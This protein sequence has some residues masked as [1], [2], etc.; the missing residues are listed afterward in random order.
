MIKTGLAALSLLLGAARLQAGDNKT[1]RLERLGTYKN[2]PFA[3]DKGAAEIVAH[4]PVTQRIFFINGDK[5]TLDVLNIQNPATPVLIMSLSL[6]PHG[7]P[8]SVDI[9]DGLVAV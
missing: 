9:R 7:R 6:T 2:V 4:D 1:I 3:L 8:T 5:N